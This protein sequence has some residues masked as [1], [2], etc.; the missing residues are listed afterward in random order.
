MIPRLQLLL[1]HPNSRR[2]ILAVRPREVKQGYAPASI[3]TAYLSSLTCVAGEHQLIFWFCIWT[4][5][6]P[7]SSILVVPTIV[8]PAPMSDWTH[9]AV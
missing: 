7:N 4:Y 8:A 3:E 5:P 9:V 6:M 1:T 2:R